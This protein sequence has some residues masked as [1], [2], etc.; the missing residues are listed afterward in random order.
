MYRIIKVLNNNSILVLDEDKKREY[1]LMGSGIGFGRRMGEH[2][3]SYE[4]AKIYSLVTRRKQQ[5]VLKAVNGIEPVYIEA[6]GKMIDIA[7]EMFSEEIN[8]DIM[9]P[10]ADHI[11][12]AAKRAFEGTQMANPLTMDIRMLFPKEYEVAIRGRKF[13][14]DMTG[15]EISDDEAGFIA[16]HIH[17]GLS[18]EQVSETLAV[19]QMIDD[20]IDI[21]KKYFQ[22]EI[23]TESLGYSRLMSHL[24]YIIARVKKGEAVNTDINSFISEKYPRAASAA[25]E[26][27]SHLE[28]CLK[29]ELMKEEMGFLAIHIHRI[30]TA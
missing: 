2:L 12:L 29:K 17:A 15:Y 25:A 3:K 16:L 23:D 30:L 20:S 7:E 9:L 1:I 19:T 5:S 11:A 24:Y 18:G 13:L 22:S 26:I 27:C 28:E 10:L 8:K 4:G 6:A 21:V 14:K